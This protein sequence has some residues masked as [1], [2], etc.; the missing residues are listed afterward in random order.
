MLHMQWST[1]Q[2]SIEH[3][4]VWFSN[5]CKSD[6]P[7]RL[8]LELQR[9]MEWIY[10]LYIYSRRR[11]VLLWENFKYNKCV[12][13]TR[14]ITRWKTSFTKLW[15]AFR[16]DELECRLLSLMEFKIAPLSHL[17]QLIL[18]FKKSMTKANF[19]NLGISQ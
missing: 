3:M 6:F 4:S 1:K 18:Y 12:I 7:S 16:R 15:R 17:P 2:F 8:T 11:K 14:N 5:K 19:E 9:P 13:F 10:W